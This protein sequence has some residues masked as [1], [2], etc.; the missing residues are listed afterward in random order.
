MN[1][2]DFHVEDDLGRDDMMHFRIQPGVQYQL[3]IPIEHRTLGNEITLEII[4]DEWEN[5]P[6]YIVFH[7]YLPARVE[8][9]KTT[10][11][12]TCCGRTPRTRC[13]ATSTRSRR[14][15]TSISPTR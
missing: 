7:E 11:R 14:L 1:I 8:D 3:R 9:L 12:C 5:A 13:S 10:A 6:R 4:G 2:M 15:G